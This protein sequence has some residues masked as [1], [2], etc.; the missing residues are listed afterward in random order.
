MPLRCGVG[1]RGV[2]KASILVGIL[3]KD[4]FVFFFD[5]YLNLMALLKRKF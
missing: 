2:S 1:V 5:L 4:V 3:C